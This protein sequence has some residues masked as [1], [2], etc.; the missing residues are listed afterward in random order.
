MARRKERAPRLGCVEVVDGRSHA[1]ELTDIGIAQVIEL[2]T[3]GHSPSEIDRY[4]NVSKGFIK[5]RIDDDSPT[6]DADIAEAFEAGQHEF[7]NR[8]RQAQ[9][10]LAVTNAQM[11]IHLGKH[12]LGQKDDVVEHN[13]THRVIGTL[14]NFTNQSI[15]DWKR[16]F[17]PEPV[18][19]ISDANV[20]DAEYE[21]SGHASNT[22]KQNAIGK[23]TS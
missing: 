8:L 5:S 16:E 21:E 22:D 18:R 13:H 11:A 17:V 23:S 15:D 19:A 7:T 10:D 4:L 3:L 9:S 14:P 2:A 1:Y 20:I 12:H 6:F